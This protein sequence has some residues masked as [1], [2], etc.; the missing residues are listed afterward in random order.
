MHHIVQRVATMSQLRV[1]FDGG[2]P[3]IA[4]VVP[5]E[6]LVQHVT[7]L[8]GTAQHVYKLSAVAISGEIY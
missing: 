1:I 2:T 5:A 4:C 6:P 7:R 8:L 3:V